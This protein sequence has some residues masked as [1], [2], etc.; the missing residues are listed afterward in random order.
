MLVLA[1]AMVRASFWQWE[2]HQEKSAYLSEMDQRIAN[3]V[4]PLKEAI[5]DV[6]E[7]YQETIHRR[8]LVDGEFDFDNEVVV[9]NRR[10]ETL[11]PGVH[12][13]TPLLL[14]ELNRYILVNRGFIPLAYKGQEERAQFQI[15]PTST[16]I[17]LVKGSERKRLLAPPDPPTGKDY[18]WVDEWIRVNIEAMQ[19][20]LPYEVLPI[21]LETM[22]KGDDIEAAKKEMVKMSSSRSEILYLGDLSEVVVADSSL[23]KDLEYPIPSYSTVIPTATHLAYVYEWLFLAALTLAIGILLQLKRSTKRQ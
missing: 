4:V 21:Y 20:Q 18:R 12:I 3:E 14:S 1:I 17:G 6:G 9:R 10:H 22:A 13:I 8:V 15:N 23:R 19:A 7:D 16:F 2:R 11:G 5:E